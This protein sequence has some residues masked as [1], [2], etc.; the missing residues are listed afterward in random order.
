MKK[1]CCDLLIAD[2]KLRIF[3]DCELPLQRK[4]KDFYAD[5]DK[6][7]V[8]YNAVNVGNPDDFIP[9]DAKEIYTGAGLRVFKLDGSVY[10]RYSYGGELSVLRIDDEKTV[11]VS[12]DELSP[13]NIQ[14][15]LALETEILGFGGAFMHASLIKVNGKGIIFSAPSG[16]G[17]STQ[18]ALWERYRGARILNGDRAAVRFVDGK[19]MAYGSPWA[20]SSGIYVN[21]SAE[22]S[23]IVFLGQSQENIVR[24][25]GGVK[26]FSALMKGGIFPYWNKEKMEM[27]CSV[28][29][30]LLANVPVFQ[31]DC[32]PDESAVE[33]L[34]KFI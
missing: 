9:R 21:D 10:H 13:I 33:E 3:S 5:F 22:L 20:G 7:D 29:E 32:R 2:M 11:Y 19:W 6:A 30:K 28:S 4:L 16:V 34:E 14:K 15:S 12:A 27:A 17:K 26:A 31:F 23:A 25:L 24:R 1:V 18:A 8:V